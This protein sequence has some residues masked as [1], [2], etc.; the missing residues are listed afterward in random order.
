MNFDL[1]DE[2]RDL[3]AAKQAKAAPTKIPRPGR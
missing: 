3:A 2:Q 1:D